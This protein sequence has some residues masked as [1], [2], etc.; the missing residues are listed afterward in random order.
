MLLLRDRGNTVIKNTS[1]KMYDISKILLLSRNKGNTAIKNTS[2]ETYDINK[3]LPSRE[4]YKRK[5]QGIIIGG[6]IKNTVTGE[7]L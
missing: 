4:Y 1:Y 5:P 3:I 2:Y 7:I 6:Y